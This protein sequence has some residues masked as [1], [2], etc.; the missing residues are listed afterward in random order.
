MSKI[1][2]DSIFGIEEITTINDSDVFTSI[3][4]SRE[5]ALD[6]DGFFIDFLPN[7]EYLKYDL[8][9]LA[10]LREFRAVC[11][12][13]DSPILPMGGCNLLDRYKYD[14]RISGKKLSDPYGRILGTFD[15]KSDVITYSPLFAHFYNERDVAKFANDHYFTTIRFEEI[16]KFYIEHAKEFYVHTDNYTSPRDLN[17]YGRYVLEQVSVSEMSKFVNE[18]RTGKLILERIRYK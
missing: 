16:M 18:P 2:Y 8:K 4:K 12:S 13:I 9:D 15:I 11:S 7:E 17:R 3:L 14:T 5:L 1:F 10:S 6:K